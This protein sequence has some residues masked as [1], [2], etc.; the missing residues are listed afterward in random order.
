[1]D[2]IKAILT[3]FLVVFASSIFAHPGHGVE[4][5]GIMHYLL[6]PTHLIIIIIA[7]GLI[8]MAFRFQTK[9]KKRDA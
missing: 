4:T 1:M 7:S 9:K 2:L 5:D 8:F 6:S 3:S